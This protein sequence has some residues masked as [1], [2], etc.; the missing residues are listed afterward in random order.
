MAKKTVISLVL[1]AAVMTMPYMA[2]AQAPYNPNYYNQYYADYYNRYYYDY[3]YNNPFYFPVL[4]AGA[5][6][7]TA[8]FIAT[9]PIRV[10]C[11]NCLPPPE[12]FYRLYLI[13]PPPPP[14]GP[15]MSYQ[16]AH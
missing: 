14:A 1:A 16:P 10:V 13:P 2:R 4:A 5:V 11:A 9:L 3:Y 15:A 8:A 6:L 12:G 7:G